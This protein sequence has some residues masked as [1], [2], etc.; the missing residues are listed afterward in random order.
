[1]AASAADPGVA[2]LAAH[3]VSKDAGTGPVHL[4]YRFCDDGV[5]AFGGSTPN[6]GGPLAVQVPAAYKGYAGLPAIDM[7]AAAQVPG[8]SAG[9]VA[10]D[11]DVSMPDPARFPPPPGGYPLV[12]MMHG[13]CSGSKTGWE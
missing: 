13:C 11:V 9:M 10:L 12:V 4:P 8:S 6:P 7:P 3:C 1:S 5:P 2:S